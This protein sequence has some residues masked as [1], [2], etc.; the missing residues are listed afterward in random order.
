MFQI[1]CTL[2][3]AVPVF[4]PM[5]SYPLN[6]GAMPAILVLLVDAALLTGL[7]PMFMR[8]WLLMVTLPIRDPPCRAPA[9]FRPLNVLQRRFGIQPISPWLMLFR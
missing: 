2:T 5:C 1:I 9:Q 8:L 4:T 7:V 6:H 3:L